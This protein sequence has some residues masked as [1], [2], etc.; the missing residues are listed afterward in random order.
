[1]LIPKFRIPNYTTESGIAGW[2]EQ[3]TNRGEGK[4]EGGE[5]EFKKTSLHTKPNNPY[6]YFTHPHEQHS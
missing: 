5:M 3:S 6:S 4:E 2:A 1:M